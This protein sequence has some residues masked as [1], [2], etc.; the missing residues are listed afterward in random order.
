MV[1]VMV[2]A[3]AA[4][5]AVAV[6]VVVVGGEARPAKRRA[7]KRALSHGRS[8]AISIGRTSPQ[9]GDPSAR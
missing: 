3:A 5:A 6:V 4:A 1:A 7:A 8:V 9:L 2:A